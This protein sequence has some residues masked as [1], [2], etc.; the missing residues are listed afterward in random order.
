MS[1]AVIKV[2]GKPYQKSKTDTSG[3][4]CLKTL[5]PFVVNA[6]Y[7]NQENPPINYPKHHYK[8]IL[9]ENL[10]KGWPYI[11]W[12]PPLTKKKNSYLLVV[13]DYFTKWVDAFPIKNQKAHTIAK[14]LIERVISIYGVPLELRSDQGRSFES[15]LFQDICIKAKV[16]I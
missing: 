9:W 13:D 4:T 5:N 8:N 16:R 10:W 6:I 11:L 3:I 12:V 14:I 1:L 15:E 2:F 7:A